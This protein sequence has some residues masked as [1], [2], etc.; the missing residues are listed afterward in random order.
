MGKKLVVV[1]A[2]IAACLS[3]C[4]QGATIVWVAEP[5]NNAAGVPFDQGWIDLLTAKG[6]TVDVQRTNNYWTTLDA[7]KLAMLEAADLIIVSRTT[8]SGGYATD[9]TE[10]TQW[11]SVTTPLID[12][13]AYLPRNSRWLWVNSASLTEPANETMMSVVRADHPIFAGVAVT[14]GQVDAIDGAVDSGQMVFLTVTDAGNGTVLAKRADNSA[15]WIA[16]WAAGTP[17]Y[18]GSTQTPAGKRMLLTGGGGT[19]QTM[20]SMNFTPAGQKIFLNAVLYMLGRP[21]NASIALDP[22]PAN[23]D[24]D[25]LR[26]TDLSWAS[27]EGAAT[28]DVYFGATLADVNEASRTNPKGVL[29]R[30]GQSSNAFDPGRLEFEATYYWR[31]D[32]VEQNGT[33]HRGELWSFTVESYSYPIAASGITPSA[34]SSTP[35]MGPEKTVDGSGLNAADQHSTVP[36]QM[37]LSAAA[38]PQPA[39][40]RYDFDRPYML[41]KLL[42]WNSNQ[43]LEG[44]VGWGA[45]D[46][47]VEY[48]MDGSAWTT[49][50]QLVF[51][52]AP[53]EAT[54]TAGTTVDF[55]NIAAK[56]VRLTIADNWGGIMPQVG[57]SEVR[58][59]TVPTFAR[60]PAP[61]AG[62]TG[63]NPKVT[64]S[65]RYGREAASHQLYLST[66]QQ[67]VIDAT[68]TPI[69]TSQASYAATV[70]LVKTYYWKVVEVNDAESPATWPSDV[71]S[72]T[73]ADYAV[74][75]D[76]ERYTN[77]S[78]NRVF[79]AWID[80]G[81]FSPDEFFP[82]GNPGNGTGSF[83]GYDPL[84]R[85]IMETTVF[86]GGG[87]SAPFFFN[88]DASVTTSETT[89]T[90][91]EPQDWTASAIKTLMVCFYGDPNNPTTVPLWVKLT[92]QGNNSAKVTFGAAAGEVLTSLA[93]PAWTE[94]NIPLSSFTGVSLA[95]VTSITIGM[96]P[97][98]GSGQ[99]FLDDIRLYPARTI[100]APAAPVLAAQWNFDNNATDS[101]GNGNN[102]TLNGGATYSATGKI[103]AALSLDGL[104]DYV[105][106]GNGASLNITDA[107]TVAAWVKTADA[108]NAQHN[109][110]VSKGNRGYVLKHYVDNY[111]QFTVYDASAWHNANGPVVTTAFNSDWHHVAGTFDGT[112]VKLYVDGKLVG[113]SLYSGAIATNTYNLNIGRNSEATD[114]LYYG[115]IDDV[116]IY[117]GVLP[118]AEIAK[119]VNP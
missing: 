55:G 9:A 57:L 39:W 14:D 19:G 35:N 72:F 5:L 93:E 33:V 85:D 50:S 86:H 101:S 16:E 7:T 105:D 88:N 97:G 21:A 40:I 102:G 109:P 115:L 84:T 26:D 114:R 47:A 25:V 90:F 70:D 69:T 108:G 53:G 117:H 31:V 64:L 68:V 111:I 20:G 65:W 82:N 87:K 18:S 110:F 100:P 30:Q 54:C 119:L 95:K 11:N 34:S 6:Y 99:L 104:D 13:A 106:C 91:D 118:S 1:I 8:N 59:L 77:D 56:S 2:L 23:G 103:G 43:S 76:F 66:D 80:G 67:A 49:L 74:V 92:D 112:Q 63:V 32:E 113:S 46:V 89:R 42:V 27:G 36:E 94:W 3:V 44:A 15:I 17:F 62:A 29:A 28:H 38:G 116:R 78:P 75:E 48:S 58:F 61:A 79:Q 96:G 107:I 60:E 52:R 73:T 24:T 41:D 81:G 10:V 51:V 37:W 98:T 12:M 22:S 45:K 83:V 4:T 71:W